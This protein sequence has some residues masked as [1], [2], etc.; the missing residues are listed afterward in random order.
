MGNMATAIK[1]FKSGGKIPPLVA[2]NALSCGESFTPQERQRLL[3]LVKTDEFWVR[4]T[5][6]RDS[7]F[8]FLSDGEK[9]QL[10]Q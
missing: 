5:L 3:E 9:K 6:T 8:S 10:S 7:K 4:E 2:S 1:V